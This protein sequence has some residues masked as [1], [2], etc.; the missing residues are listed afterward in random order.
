MTFFIIVVLFEKA[1]KHESFIKREL[2]KKNKMT[3]SLRENVEGFASWTRLG[4]DQSVVNE[5]P[6]LVLLLQSINSTIIG[7]FEKFIGAATHKYLIN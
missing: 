6:F 4:C 3:F 1:W 7:I 2:E 5:L